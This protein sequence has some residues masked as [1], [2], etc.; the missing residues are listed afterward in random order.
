MYVSICYLHRV[1]YHDLF[2]P[3]SYLLRIIIPNE[4]KTSIKKLVKAR[5]ASGLIRNR[6]VRSMDVR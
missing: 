2:C 3:D 5:Y 6:A 1:V 4:Y